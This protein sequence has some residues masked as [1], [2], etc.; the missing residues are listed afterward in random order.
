MWEVSREDTLTLSDSTS[1]LYSLVREDS[2]V[3]SDDLAKDFF[4]TIVDSLNFSDSITEFQRVLLKVIADSLTITDNIE[5]QR[6]IN[7][8]LADVFSISD[9]IQ[10][11]ELVINKQLSD[12][13]TLVDNLF[14]TIE[15]TKS[16]NILLSDLQIKDI[17]TKVDD[18]FSLI[19]SWIGLFTAEIT[20]ALNATADDCF[21]SIKMDD[22]ISDSTILIEELETNIV[23][24]DLFCDIVVDLDLICKIT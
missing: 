21:V 11:T 10:L 16:E 23:S 22:V 3:C 15:L 20:I 14:K 19:D 2:F 24:D 1:N 5:F 9:N 17:E 7:Q 8:S 13:L 18:T 6:I 12:T 4:R